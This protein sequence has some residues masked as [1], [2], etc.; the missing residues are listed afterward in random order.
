M[1]PRFLPED[2]LRHYDDRKAKWRQSRSLVPAE[3]GCALSHLSV[4]RTMIER[5]LEHALILEDDVTLPSN[6]KSFLNR[7]VKY[8]ESNTPT[9][10]LLS[11]AVGR[12]TNM[13]PVSIGAAHCLLP[14]R[15]GYYASS[16]LL[17]LPAA[18]ALLKELYPVGDVADCWKRMNRY[19]VVDLY[20]VSPPLIEQNQDKFGSST[21][22]RHP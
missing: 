14:Y 9:V 2:R 22:S 20:V 5:G 6:L 11:P 3:I 8:L 15:A 13:P 12:K 19:R 16:Y 7:C 1:V 17:T 10:W 4:Y 21:S 18:R